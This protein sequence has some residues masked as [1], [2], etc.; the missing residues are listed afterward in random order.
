MSAGAGRSI[1]GVAF[2]TEIVT[3][4]ATGEAGRIVPA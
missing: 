3:F 2:V 4:S 1:T